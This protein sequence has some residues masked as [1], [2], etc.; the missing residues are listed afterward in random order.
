MHRRAGG[1][2]DLRTLLV[3]AVA[4]CRR[5]QYFL[6]LL[7][8]CSFC[9]LPA[10]RSPLPARSQLR[11]SDSAD[12]TCAPEIASCLRLAQAQRLPCFFFD[13][14]LDASGDCSS[15]ACGGSDRVEGIFYGGGSDS[16]EGTLETRLLDGAEGSTAA[17][18]ATA[19]GRGEPVALCM[20]SDD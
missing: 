13:A 17:V 8:P 10:A 2:I 12:S 5:R 7:P 6:L 3:V 19:A 20:L 9:Q 1:H 11:A 4:D 18:A 15:G 16:D 14:L